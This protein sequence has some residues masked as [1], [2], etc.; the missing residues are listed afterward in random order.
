MFP[1]MMKRFDWIIWNKI[2]NITNTSIP[3]P[4]TVLLDPSIFHSSKQTRKLKAITRL[5]KVPKGK[6]RILVVA[7]SDTA[8]SNLHVSAFMNVA[9][10]KGV[11]TSFWYE[12]KD[13]SKSFVNTIPAGF[14]F[15][16]IE[17][18]GYDNVLKAIHDSD[19][20]PKSKFVLTAW[21]K[22]YPGIHDEHIAIIPINTTITLRFRSIKF[23]K[24]IG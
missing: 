7:G 17:Q 6:K 15:N 12:A 13:I 18:A 16:Y 14:K 24:I 21:G 4:R 20:I 1:A 22:V 10:A 19:H 2:C 23:Q 3:N 8:L 5:G 11:F 9:V